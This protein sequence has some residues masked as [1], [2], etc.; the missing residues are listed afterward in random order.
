MQ[1]KKRKTLLRKNKEAKEELTYESNIGLSS[2]IDVV[3]EKAAIDDKLPPIIVIFDLET[4]GFDS[5][6][7]ILQIAALH[8]GVSFCAYIR[9]RRRIPAK[10]T[11]VHGIKY[12]E[13]VLTH[14][15]KPIDSKKYFPCQMPYS[16]SIY[17]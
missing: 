11:A 4:S 8:E 17:F 9:P 1:L 13:G 5:S 15:S 2:S 14:N 12:S 3:I 6:A 7:E 10:S 16:N